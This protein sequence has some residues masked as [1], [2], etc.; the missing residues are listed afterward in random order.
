[1]LDMGSSSCIFNE[2]EQM[3]LGCSCIGASVRPDTSVRLTIFHA[4]RVDR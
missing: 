1:M 3:I 2:A 4:T